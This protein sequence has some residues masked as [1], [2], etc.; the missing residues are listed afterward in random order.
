MKEDE[1][2]IKNFGFAKY[3]DPDVEQEDIEDE[4]FDNDKYV[5]PHEYIEKSADLFR[6]KVPFKNEKYKIEHKYE[7][8]E[9]HQK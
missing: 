6:A 8:G 1:Q 5:A 7:N 2:I 4:D 3:A 9:K